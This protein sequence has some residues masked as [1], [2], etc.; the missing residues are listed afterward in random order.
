MAWSPK[1]R[2]DYLFKILFDM[3]RSPKLRFDYLFIFYYIIYEW[4]FDSIFDYKSIHI[5]LVLQ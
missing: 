5:K 3:A 1:L 2:F 4:L